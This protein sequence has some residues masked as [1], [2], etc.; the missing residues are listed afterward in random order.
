MNFRVRGFPDEIG[1]SP[2]V[3]AELNETRN[4][5]Q[6]PNPNVP[7]FK[8]ENQK[9]M[10]FRHSGLRRNDGKGRFPTFFQVHLF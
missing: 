4:I 8:N 6:I 2:N 3:T 5:K 10:V 1:L 7:T 9:P